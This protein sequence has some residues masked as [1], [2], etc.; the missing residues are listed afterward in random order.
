MRLD[1]RKAAYLRQPSIS[2]FQYHHLTEQDFRAVQNHAVDVLR[3]VAPDTLVE[4]T[5]KLFGGDYPILNYVD[6]YL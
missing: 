5:R 4:Y 6:D 1:L 2:N 3:M